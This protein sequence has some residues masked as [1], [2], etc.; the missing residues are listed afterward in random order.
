M[1]FRKSDNLTKLSEIVRNRPKLHLF[2]CNWYRLVTRRNHSGTTGPRRNLSGTACPE[3]LENGPGRTNFGIHHWNVKQIDARSPHL[4]LK[5]PKRSN[6]GG[7]DD[8]I[9]K[10]ISARSPKLLPE[11]GGTEFI[12]EKFLH[13]NSSARHIH[14]LVKFIRLTSS[15]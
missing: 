1:H 14:P 5:P 11:L 8:W 15:V 9:V 3:T 7:T 13:L 10:E 4:A 6:F 2:F 12:R